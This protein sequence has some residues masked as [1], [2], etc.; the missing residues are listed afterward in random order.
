MA[1]KHEVEISLRDKGKVHAIIITRQDVLDAMNVLEPEKL[2]VANFHY[3]GKYVLHPNT[4]ERYGIK[5]V[6]TQIIKMKT[7]I[8]TTNFTTNEVQSKLEQLGFDYGDD[9]TVRPVLSL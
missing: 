4:N 7:T 8:E 5:K 3:H 1:K 2:G 6:I 9:K